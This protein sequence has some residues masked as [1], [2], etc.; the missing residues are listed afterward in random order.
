MSAPSSA[1]HPIARLPEEWAASLAARGARSYAAKQ[2]FSWIH[3]RGVMEAGRMTNV[4]GTL[5][6][7]LAEEGLAPVCSVERVHRSTD[8]TRKLLVRLHD[9][10]TIETVLI[11]TWS[12]PGPGPELD[13]DA[14]AADLEDDAEEAAGPTA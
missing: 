5:R 8:G 12:G 6:T 3:R 13:A 7:A 14:A 1:P 2:V 4:A 9:S 10:A 11:P